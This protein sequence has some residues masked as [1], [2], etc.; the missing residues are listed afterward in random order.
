MHK[1]TFL[2]ACSTLQY[3]IAQYWM[4]LPYIGEIHT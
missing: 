1:T 4:R 2:F 3:L